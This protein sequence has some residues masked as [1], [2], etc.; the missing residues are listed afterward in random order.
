MIHAIFR[1]MSIQTKLIVAGTIFSLVITLFVFII[2]PF[3]QR[4]QIISQSQ[5][6]ATTV[7]RIIAENLGASLIFHDVETA[8][9]VLSVLTKSRDFSFALAYDKSGDL[10]VSLNAESAPRALRRPARTSAQTGFTIIKD[11][12]VTS[13]P[14]MY[15]GMNVGTVAI[16]FSLARLNRQITHNMLIAAAAAIALLSIM[17]FSYYF[18]GRIIVR[19]LQKITAATSAIAHGDFSRRLEVTS[20]DETGQ[21]AQ[22]VNDMTEQLH[23]TIVELERSEETYRTHFE[24]ISDMIFSLNEQHVILSISPS[25]SRLLGYSPDELTGRP[26]NELNILSPGD[27]KRLLSDTR[28]ALSGEPITSKEY[29]FIAKNGGRKIFETSISPLKR[30][31]S[32]A[33]AVSVARDITERKRVLQELKKTRDNLD[34]IIESSQ[35]A[36]IVTDS[37]AHITRVNR[38]FLD[39]VGFENEAEVKGKYIT[40]I[41]PPEGSYETLS[42]EA[43]IISKQFFEDARRINEELFSQGKVT[44]WESYLLNRSNR[45]IPVELSMVLLAPD[46]DSPPAAV[47]I[48]RDISERKKAERNLQEA[49]EFNE[50]VI[51]SSRDG[52]IIS[53]AQGTIVSVNSAMERI[54]GYSK[55]ELT[56]QRMSFLASRDPAVLE[57]I[58]EKTRLLMKQGFIAY[59]MKQQTKSGN[60]IDV[61]YSTSMIR[62]ESGSYVAAVSIVRDITERRRIEAQLIRSEKMRSLGELAGGVAH[63]FNNILAA[64]L[65]RA[66]WLQAFIQPPPHITEKRASTL[67][68][69]KGLQIIE[70][71]SLDGAETVRRIQEFSRQ[72]EQESLLS[73]VDINSLLDD[74]LEFTR[75]LWK[76]DAESRGITFSINRDYSTLR[77]TVANASEL[78]EVFTNIIKNALESMPGGGSVFIRTAMENDSAISVCIQDTGTGIPEQELE[79][80]FDPFFTTKG[81]QSAG[82]GMSVSYGIINRH[83]GSISAGNAPEG[84]AL[85]TLTLPVKT[86]SSV[87]APQHLPVETSPDRPASILVIDD[88]L[89][90]REMLADILAEGGHRVATA[91]DGKKGLELFAEKGFDIVFTDLG[92]PDMSGQDVAREIKKSSRSAPVILITGWQVKLNADQLRSGGID[93][94]IHK[95]FQVT[96]VLNM[97]QGMLRGGADS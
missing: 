56:G 51:E 41:I 20:R 54:S 87:C 32:G 96:D 50:K 81:P 15:R 28:W 16:G 13:L 67:E 17:I 3:Q 1:N 29:E 27:L 42:G 73:R 90:V 94:V 55:S 64:I 95:P 26:L 31:A 25:V 57:T 68:L 21:L 8:R 11:T 58:P 60:T 49:K 14:V 19:P 69:E 65:G 40:S 78:R 39:L 66:Q 35:D 75:M 37:T 59:E 22:A 7:A 91:E 86:A 30:S 18:I 44:N 80:I 93:S 45:V 76:N 24:N 2:F 47:A 62:D 63:D 10:F 53:N 84:G 23:A 33:A 88:D 61:E 9:E 12:A 83:Q 52:I 74:A 82:L 72:N 38:Y 89:H 77:P 4:S 85:F 71:A 43:V 36:I 34:N 97:V 5:E 70:K 6:R 92:M 46:K 48:I 79:R